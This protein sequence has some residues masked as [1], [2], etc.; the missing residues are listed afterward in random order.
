MAAPDASAGRARAGLLQCLCGLAGAPYDDAE[1]AAP[2][3]LLLAAGFMLA[4]VS[5]VMCLSALPLAGWMLAP[6]PGLAALPLVAMIVGSGLAT[7]PAVLLRDAF[8]R[9]AAFAL[10]ASLGAAGGAMA[11]WALIEHQFVILTLGALW[12][13]IA[14]GFGLFYRHEAAMGTGRARTRAVGL[15][16]SAGALAG[17]IAPGVARFAEQALFPHA[18]AG[19]LT[20]AA[21]A[22]VAAL[23]MTT[24]L[25]LTE[26]RDRQG[27]AEQAGDWSGLVAATVFAAFAWFSMG[28]LMVIAP[29]GLSGCGLSFADVSGVVA[30]H[31]IAMYAPAMLMPALVARIGTI[32][33][34]YLGMGLLLAGVGMAAMAPTAVLLTSGYLAV[35]AGWSLTTAAAT[36]RIGEAEPERLQLALHDAVLF[37]A[38]LAGMLTA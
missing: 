32:N 24:R 7:L 35:G 1:P 11:A 6:R 27:R 30:W 15:V 23:A 8:G 18:F 33:F 3:V 9:R 16:V 34:Q 37:A 22:H 10:G 36:L 2:R 4:V 28:R 14:Q 20:V 25:P 26:P 31:V 17:F 38:A 29:I 13:G 12:L 5:Q 19:A 21:A